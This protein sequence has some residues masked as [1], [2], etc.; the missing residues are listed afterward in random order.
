MNVCG[1]G[2]VP[3]WLSSIPPMG[4]AWTSPSLTQA[5]FVVSVTAAPT[6][7]GQPC[8]IHFRSSGHSTDL[9]LKKVFNNYKVNE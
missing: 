2:P 7:L 4:P 6:S 5:E 1:W 9:A 3:F 8:L